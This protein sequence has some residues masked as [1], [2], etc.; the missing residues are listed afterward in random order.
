MTGGGAPAV[1]RVLL[2]CVLA[3][4][5]L[6][7]VM[8]YSVS[9][10]RAAEVYGDGFYFLKRQSVALVVGLLVLGVSIRMKP[11]FWNR[12]AYPLLG[13][14]IVCLVL[15]LIPGIGAQV[16]GARRWIRAGVASFQPSELTKI[17]FLLYIA[18]SI[19]KK[20]DKMGTW[21]VGILTHG[22]VLI[23]LAGLLLAEPDL[24]TVLVLGFLAAGLLFLGGAKIAH[25][26]GVLFLALPAV[27][28]LVWHSP[29]RLRRILSFLDPWNAPQSDG[30]QIIQS[31]LAFGSGGVVGQGLGD[32]RQ[33]LFFLPEAHTDFIL[34]VIGEEL[35]LIG[36]ATVVFLFLTIFLR[37][38]RIARSCSDPFAQLLAAGISL[39]LVVEALTNAAV[40]MGIFPTKGLALPLVSYGGTSLVMTLWACGILLGLSAHG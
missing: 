16:G 15:V 35:G 30:F 12:L 36:V 37:G 33:K 8:V 22:V 40:V 9:S 17:V 23:I 24:G 39:L 5:C 1:D 13:A 14:A 10:V 31:F 32:S 21:S 2:G 18:K 38:M 20:S 28:F 3:L 26:A 7:L 19:S 34:S 29:Y 4:S 27:G 25:L 6:G 11:D